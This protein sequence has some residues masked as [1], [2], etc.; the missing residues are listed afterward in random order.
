MSLSGSSSSGGLPPGSPSLSSSL[1]TGSGGGVTAA[2]GS[3]SGALEHVFKV[4]IIGEG[5]TG[6]TALIRR[7]VDNTWD[8]TYKS[9]LGVDF[10][11]KVID[12]SKQEHVRLQLWDIAGQERFQ[13]MT[14]V[15]YRS[16]AA[17]V[18]VFDL[19]QRW[20]FQKVRGWKADVDSKVRLPNNEV[21][22]CMLIANKCDL[23]DRQVSREEID[24]FAREMGFLCWF[25]TS[26]KENI[27]IEKAIKTLVSHILTI[28]I[29]PGHAGVPGNR[30]RTASLANAT[31]PGGRSDG[32]LQVKEDA[33]APQEGG[34]CGGK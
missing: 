29:A 33:P 5:T 26:A 13:H 31:F 1:M 28:P 16:A 7:Y 23:P 30:V 20:S 11:L 8:R 12:I 19:T 24:E 22:P 3:T 14:R 25:E 10:A 18:V 9:T 2:A 32:A 17:A 34:C 27:N 6:K 21:I 4:I 15:Y